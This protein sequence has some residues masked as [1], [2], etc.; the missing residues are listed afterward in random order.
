MANKQL[1][2]IRHA[3]SKYPIGVPD[4]DRPLSQRGVADAGA[5]AKW[6]D[7][8]GLRQR[9]VAVVV[10]SARRTQETWSLIKGNGV[11]SIAKSEPQLYEATPETIRSVIVATPPAVEVLIVIAHNP[12][13]EDLATSIASNPQSAAFQ[14]MVGKFP[15]SGIA[16]FELIDWKSL[17][18]AS[19]LLTDFVVPR[20]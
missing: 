3:K 17:G 20:G 11:D 8:S 1:V 6:V 5:V 15:T 13:L 9:Q 12:G 4:S 18:A 16:V 10:S 7:A 14:Q 2:L 19:A